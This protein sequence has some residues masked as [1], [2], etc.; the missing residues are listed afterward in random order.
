MVWSIVWVGVEAGRKAEFLSLLNL[1]E[2]A[3]ADD[4]FE[5]SWTGV[6]SGDW[7][8]IALRRQKDANPDLLKAAS[9]NGHAL[10]ATFPDDTMASRL[11][12]WDRGEVVWS[13]VHQA[14]DPPG[15]P[16]VDGETPE[17]FDEL[18]RAGHTRLERT[19]DVDPYPV[20]MVEFA[21][22]LTGFRAETFIAGVGP[23]RLKPMAA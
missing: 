14:S 19:P 12:M 23:V 8:I 11:Q 1:R 7:Y 17:G 5:S 10:L 6:A 3:E 18:L 16:T 13:I 22:R 20:L 2:T 4:F 9:A 21:Q 15:E